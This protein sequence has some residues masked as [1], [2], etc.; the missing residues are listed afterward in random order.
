MFTASATHLVLAEEIAPLAIIF[1]CIYVG[2]AW[3]IGH[4]FDKYHFLTFRDPLTKV[5]NRRYGYKVI[6][7]MLTLARRKKESFAILNIDIDNF[8]C[9][10]DT[11]GHEYGDFILEELC[12]ILLKSLRKSDPVIRWGGD[13]FLVICQHVNREAAAELVL[14]LHKNVNALAMDKQLNLRLSIGIAI[15]PEDGQTMDTLISIS[16]EE[17][18]EVKASSKQNDSH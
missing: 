12:Q 2:F 5:Y 13:E 8:K 15:Y 4:L 9:I 17:M 1:S 6:P 14:R 10:N 3:L 11:Y 16:D 18:Y 7:R